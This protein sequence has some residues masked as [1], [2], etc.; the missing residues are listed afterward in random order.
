[1]F[2]FIFSHYWSAR[3]W[4]SL[5]YALWQGVIDSGILP[6]PQMAVF[7]G[8]IG[9]ENDDRMSYESIERHRLG[10]DTLML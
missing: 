3:I 10:T 2:N 6:R 9:H 1:M 5:I 8:S 7:R 4:Y